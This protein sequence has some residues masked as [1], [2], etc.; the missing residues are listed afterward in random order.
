MTALNCSSRPLYRLRYS[1]CASIAVLPLD[2]LRNEK[3][4]F[5]SQAFPARIMEIDFQHIERVPYVKR[6]Y[7]LGGSTETQFFSLNV[8]DGNS[9]YILVQL[10]NMQ[11]LKPLIRVYQRRYDQFSNV[12]YDLKLDDFL[13]ISLF[14]KFIDTNQN[15]FLLK[16]SNS[17]FIYNIQPRYLDIHTWNI[18]TSELLGVKNNP[19]ER[20]IFSLSITARN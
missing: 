11:D 6:I 3:T 15:S 5:V 18:T 14:V 9:D 8:V 10:I 7:R 1:T 4:L 16:N 20:A 12:F 17:F 2:S 13:D 19:S